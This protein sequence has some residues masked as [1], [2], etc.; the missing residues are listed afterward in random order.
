M[1]AGAAMLLGTAAATAAIPEHLYMVGEASP[2][3][4]HI[5]LAIEMTNE[6]DGV[7]SYRG[8]LY[9][10]NLQFIDARDWATGVRYVP[11]VSG[12]WLIDAG[13]IDFGKFDSIV[14]EVK[15]HL[16]FQLGCAV[17]IGK[18][19]ELV[20]VTVIPRTSDFQFV[21]EFDELH[22]PVVGR[23]R[24]IEPCFPVVAGVGDELDMFAICTRHHGTFINEDIFCP[25]L[26]IDIVGIGNG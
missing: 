19:P 21:T 4:W 13:G 18:A 22:N 14:I 11:E 16:D 9:N 24:Q 8:A 5:D 6:G 12:W 20:E 15:C 7:F 26:R 23:F 1:L 3:L 17:F 2:S 10:Q 25:F